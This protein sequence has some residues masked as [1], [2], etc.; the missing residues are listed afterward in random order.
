MIYTI[1]AGEALLHHS[2]MPKY[3]LISPRLKL[4]VQKPGELTFTLPPEH[5]N[6]DAVSKLRPEIKVM[7][8]S[9]VL[10]RGRALEDKLNFNGTREIYCRGKLSYLQDTLMPPES[11]EGNSDTLFN[12]MLLDHNVKVLVHQKIFPGEITALLP[13]NLDFPEYMTTFDRLTALCDAASAKMVLRHEQDGDYL[14]LLSDYPVATSQKIVF[15]ENLLDLKRE[16]SAEKVYSACIPL[17]AFETDENGNQTSKRSTLKPLLGTEVLYDL[18]IVNEY[19]WIYAPPAETTFDDA[20]TVEELLSKGQGYMASKGGL[21]ESNIELSALDL[22]FSDEELETFQVCEYVEVHSPNHGLLETY[23]I[24]QID[25]D[26]LDPAK[27]KMTLGQKSLTLTDANQKKEVEAAILVNELKAALI[28]AEA[29]VGNEVAKRERYIRYVDGII[30]LGESDSDLKMRLSNT[31]LSFW[32]S[33]YGIETKVAYIS[34]PTGN[35][36]DSKLYIE[37]AAILQGI[38]FGAY[39]W[40]PEDNGS[41]SLVFKG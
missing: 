33:L 13:I 28:Q 37:N 23:L 14:D 16:V 17:G 1:Y 7:R 9:K 39:A 26:L 30:E 40:E 11:M 12:K 32:E 20:V 2:G 25:L 38:S 18:A 4:E 27:T 41:V 19:G 35:L 21:L 6:G 29:V 10:F 22:S 36:G 8:D 34:N 24:S 5:P 3:S 15:S 31:E